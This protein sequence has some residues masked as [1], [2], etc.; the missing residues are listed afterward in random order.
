V[1]YMSSVPFYFNLGTSK[2]SYI[3]S[4]FK[5]AYLIAFDFLT[6]I[7]DNSNN[8]ILYNDYTVA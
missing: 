4:Y 8:K 6:P 3:S 5:H 7:A 1:N 2:V